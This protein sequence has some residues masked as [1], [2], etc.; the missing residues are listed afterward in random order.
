MNNPLK[1]VKAIFGS[2]KAVAKAYNL[3]QQAISRWTHIPVKHARKTQRLTGG[4][5][6]ADAVLE[7]DEFVRVN[8]KRR[9]SD[10]QPSV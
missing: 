6:L 9:A 7:Y 10:Q 4:K 3:T 8:K 5:V 2:Q 1:E